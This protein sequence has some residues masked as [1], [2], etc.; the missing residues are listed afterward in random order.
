MFTA[1]YDTTAISSYNLTTV[2]RELKIAQIN[3]ELRAVKNSRGERID[4]VFE[5]PP[6]VKSVPTFGHPIEL[7]LD[8]QT[9][10]VIDTRAFV[11]AT[12]QP[13]TIITNTADYRFLSLRASLSRAWA[14]GGTTAFLSTGDLGP[15][16]FVSMISEGLSRRLGLSPLE[17]MPLAVLTALYYYMQFEKQPPTDE[18][19]T[20]MI[21]ARI[22]RITRVPSAR[23]FE[24]LEQTQYPMTLDEYAV[25]VRTV[26]PNPRLH[27]LNSAVLY[28]AV[29][30]AWFGA[31]AREV[32]AVAMEYPPY[33]MS[34]LYT[35][36]TS[37]AYSR[38]IFGTTVKRFDRHEAGKDLVRALN[39]VLRT[40]EHD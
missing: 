24:I 17:Q 23:V 31:N 22:A 6:Y 33:L 21:A 29:G 32:M 12:D 40:I 39:P 10:W 35:C 2:I 15:N 4:G 19:F 3:G 36:L 5:V 9:I 11:K 27:A 14:D 28:T 7:V 8:D 16:L 20:T 26:I 13:D 37:S 38:S 25:Q 18:A 30:G 34:M 1:P